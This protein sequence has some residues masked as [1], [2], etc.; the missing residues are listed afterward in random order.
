MIRKQKKNE[1]Y[2]FM[3]LLLTVLLCHD[4]TNIYT[5]EGQNVM[6]HLRNPLIDIQCMLLIFSR[7]FMPLVQIW[8]L[9]HIQF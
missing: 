7:K 4:F 9:G 2:V 6:G 1:L 5:C 3:F 8:Y